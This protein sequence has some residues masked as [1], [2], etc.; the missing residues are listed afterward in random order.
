MANIVRSC[1]A[2]S[3]MFGMA[4]LAA[5]AAAGIS[6]ECAFAIAS[7]DDA[8]I[9]SCSIQLCVHTGIKVNKRFLGIEEHQ[10]QFGVGICTWSTCSAA[11]FSL[12]FF[13]PIAVTKSPAT[14]SNA[15]QYLQQTHPQACTVV[16]CIIPSRYVAA[17]LHER[18]AVLAAHLWKVL[19]AWA[20][21]VQTL[22]FL[23]LSL[24]RMVP[25]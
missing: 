7:F 14:S 19:Q 16:Q 20:D 1:S 25:K 17:P 13:C 24:S 9:H 23:S 15:R 5:A 8:S 4:S 11:A 10:L 22:V 12:G 3:R 21:C 18:E 2:A 6:T